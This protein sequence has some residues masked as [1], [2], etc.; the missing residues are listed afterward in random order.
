[1]RLKINDIYLDPIRVGDRLEFRFNAPEDL[2]YVTIEKDDFM[3][4]LELSEIQ[5]EQST[6]S[7]TFVEPM[8]SETVASGIFKSVQGISYEITNPDSDTWATIKQ[9]VDGSIT[10]YHDGVIQST[11][12]QTIEDI[13]FGI[14]DIAGGN[15]ASFNLR[16][17]G[18]QQSVKDQ[19]FSSVQTQLAG[20]VGI[21]LEDIEGNYNTLLDTDRKSV[22]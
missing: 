3:G 5:L 8:E 7:T 18:I 9:S 14:S 17:G 2:Q 16:L 11:I 15:E 19:M 21:Q 12:A 4:D 1:M 20:F 6:V 13:I 10:T 22:V